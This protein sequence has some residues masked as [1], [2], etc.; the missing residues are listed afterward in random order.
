MN[1]WLHRISH[2]AEISYPL[3]EREFLSIGFSDFASTEFIHRTESDGWDYFDS[4]FQQKWN[5]IPRNRH[6][7]WRFIREMKKG[8]RVLVPSWGVFSVYQ[9]E[10]DSAHPIG[11]IDS[12]G[13]KTWSNE[14]VTKK[15][16]S[17]LYNSA[18]KIDLGFFR[19]V[20]L[21]EAN[22]SRYKYADSALT[23]RMKIRSTNANITDLKVNLEKALSAFKDKRPINLHSQ[24]MEV[25][26]QQI[27]SLILQELNDHKFELLLKWYFEKIGASDVSIPPKNERDKRGDAD[28]VA[29]FEP[30]KTI[31][32]IQAK[33]YDGE[34]SD[35]ATKQIKEYRENKEKIDD[36]YSKIG[37]VVSTSGKFSKQCLDLAKDNNI[38]LFNGLDIVQML[39]DAGIENLD[40]ALIKD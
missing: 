38:A 11:D 12:D 18:N 24:I 26:K 1:I 15:E 21:I 33:F 34:T 25:S 19:K 16:D 3:L 10:E 39:L 40:K 36:G 4:E 8:D 20:T 7:L 23:S 29:V 5:S 13:L 35:W 37:W 28:I 14:T 22:I 9:I 31:Y 17:F 6:N 32:Y 30:T 2:H 27:L